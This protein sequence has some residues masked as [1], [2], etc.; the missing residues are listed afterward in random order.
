MINPP[1]IIGWRVRC[2]DCLTIDNYTDYDKAVHRWIEHKD[3]LRH[4]FVYLHPI[5]ELHPTD[6]PAPP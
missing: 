1:R 4:L 5:H 6:P 3:Q 2:E